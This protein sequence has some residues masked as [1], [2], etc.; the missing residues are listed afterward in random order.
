MEDRPT[1]GEPGHVPTAPNRG[2][3]AIIEE[4]YPDG[5]TPERSERE[6]NLQAIECGYSPQELTRFMALT[7]FMA[8]HSI[9]ADEIWQI[10]R[11]GL[12]HRRWGS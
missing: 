8:R 6:A 5:W 1:S 2:L 10:I 11:V 3:F 7:A 4:L 12:H 9:T